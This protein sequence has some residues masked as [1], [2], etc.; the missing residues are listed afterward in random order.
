MQDPFILDLTTDSTEPKVTKVPFKPFAGTVLIDNAMTKYLAYNQQKVADAVKDVK[1][2]TDK[3]IR[4]AL[5]KAA[6]TI[7]NFIPEDKRT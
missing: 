5:I 4:K 7:Y 3:M 1:S 2:N 6:D